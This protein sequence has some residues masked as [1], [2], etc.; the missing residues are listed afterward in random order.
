MNPTTEIGLII[1]LGVAAQWVAA[2]FRFPSILLLLGFGLA[3]G[4]GFGW[5]D[6]DKLFGDLLQPL[7]SLSVAIILF[8]GGLS[9]HWKE[10][11]SIGRPLILLVSIGALISS[12][13][14]TFAARYLLDFPWSQA[15]LLGAI[16]VVTGPTVIAPLLRHLR[17]HGNAAA[18]LR[19]EGIVIDPLG[20][21]FAVLVFEFVRHGPEGTGEMIALAVGKT[22]IVG[23]GIGWF[24][25]VLLTQAMSRFHLP[26]TLQNPV[27]FAMAILA[28]ISANAVQEEAGLFAV[29]VMGIALANQR[30][31]PIKH[32]LEFKEN[33][34]VLLISMLFI[35]LSARLPRS[36]IADFDWQAVAFLISLLG[37]RMIAVWVS[38]LGSTLT[39]AERIFV[40]CL[41]PR[42]IVA[43]AVASVFA[44]KLTRGDLEAVDRLSPMV[45]WTIIGTVSIYGLSAAPL[46]R[47]L[48][49]AATNPQGTIFIGGQA[50][51][52]ALAKCLQDLGKPVIIVDSSWANIMAARWAGLTAHF[53]SALSEQTL[54]ELEL[55]EMRRM[56]AVTA[57]DELNS[58]ACQRFKES[59]GRQNVFQLSFTSPQSGRHEAI[60]AEQRGRILISPEATYSEITHWCGV[61]PI[62][63]ATVITAGFDYAAFQSMH[64]ERAIPVFI[65]RENGDLQT[66]AAGD[67]PLQPK[68]GQTVISLMRSESAEPTPA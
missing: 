37:I 44:L 34:T 19:W 31:T 20:A 24:L 12:V 68:A 3:V 67:G 38:T 1:V 10:F 43:A 8:E 36:A 5:I 47:Y 49:L 14:T 39:R 40:A 21:L 50:W 63:K 33:L 65:L 41:A 22:L 60:P 28:L 11:Q 15:A 2:R 62:A 17:L 30:K 66:I 51:V 29:T 45:F 6:P 52:R 16:L 4:P 9:L 53:G 54:D 64:G 48:G 18:L 35:I 25:A 13:L 59:F 32:L 27:T 7:V 58:L 46:A 55:G 42:G 26:D 61:A 57:N 23:F 56:L